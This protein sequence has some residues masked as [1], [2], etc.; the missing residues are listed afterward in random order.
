MLLPLLLDNLNHL[1]GDLQDIV[2][3]KN[4]IFVGA[5]IFCNLARVAHHDVAIAHS[6]QLVDTMLLA[7]LV[8]LR[9]KARHEGNHVLWLSF[10]TVVAEARDVRVQKSHIL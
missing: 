2:S 9:E 6:V 3:F 7:Q 4:G 10:L 8:K 5:S 1:H